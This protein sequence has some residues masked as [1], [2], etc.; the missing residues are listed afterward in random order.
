MFLCRENKKRCDSVQ[1]L[2]SV[3][4]LALRVF[5]LSQFPDFLKFFLILKIELIARK[6]IALI[7]L[8]CELRL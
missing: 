7:R 8:V 5:V 4:G 2:H 3:L 1:A 6:W